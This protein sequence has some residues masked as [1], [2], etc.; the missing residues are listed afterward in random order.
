M[1][2]IK[3]DVAQSRHE[4]YFV[5][6]WFLASLASINLQCALQDHRSMC[7]LILFSCSRLTLNAY[8]IPNY[9]RP[10][11]PFSFYLPLENISIFLPQKN[12]FLPTT[13]DTSKQFL[14]IV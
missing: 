1:G 3:R 12:L 8:P 5:G 10:C 13:V 14:F 7:C 11:E 2:T 4:I 6:V 9:I